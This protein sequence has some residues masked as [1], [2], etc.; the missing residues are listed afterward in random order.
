MNFNYPIGEHVEKG[1]MTFQNRILKSNHMLS[2]WI[3]QKQKDVLMLREIKDL[4]LLCFEMLLDRE[5]VIIDS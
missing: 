3:V 2:K 4:M 5:G 1:M